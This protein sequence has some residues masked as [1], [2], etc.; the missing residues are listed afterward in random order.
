MKSLSR[1]F[2]TSLVVFLSIAV[3]AAVGYSQPM[4]SDK[5]V[6]EGQ[7]AI[8]EGAKKMMDGNKMIM[9]TMN[10]KGVKDADLTSAEKMMTDGYDM[11]TKG[12]NMMTGSTMA[13]GKTMVTRGAKMMLD[14]QKATSAAVEKHGMTQECTI[15]LDSC[16]YGEKKIKEG[17]LEWFF[18][19]GGI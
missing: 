19:A 16:T 1:Y 9:D 7:K 6:E 5:G 15:G 17:A 14:A 4:K 8:M 13:E 10:K 3:F 2:A 18:G 11:I 12:Q